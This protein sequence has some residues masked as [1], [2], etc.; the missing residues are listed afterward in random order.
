M[1][2]G[3]RRRGADIAHRPSGVWPLLVAGFLP[4]D[5]LPG[6]HTDTKDTWECSCRVVLIGPLLSLPGRLLGPNGHLGVQLP[7]SEDTPQWS[8][9]CEL[10]VQCLSTQEAGWQAHALGGAHCLGTAGT[11]LVLGVQLPRIDI[12]SSVFIIPHFPSAVRRQ[13]VS[14]ITMAARPKHMGD[15]RFIFAAFAPN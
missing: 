8:D 9:D 1:Q 4:L 6:Y 5:A 7:G 14:G 3:Q 15:S 11:R 13:V 10:L 12:Y 2:Q